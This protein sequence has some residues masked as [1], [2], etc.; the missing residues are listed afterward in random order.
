METRGTSTESYRLLLSCL[1]RPRH[2]GATQLSETIKH[3]EAETKS[4]SE[5]AHRTRIGTEAIQN[6]TIEHTKVEARK[7]EA[8]AEEDVERARI[9]AARTGEKAIEEE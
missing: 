7:A 8:K 5:A 4:G 6:K 9:Y 3:T 1:S 2:R